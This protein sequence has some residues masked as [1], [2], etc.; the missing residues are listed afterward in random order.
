MIRFRLPS[1]ILEGDGFAVARTFARLVD[2]ARARD[3]SSLEVRLPSYIVNDADALDLQGYDRGLLRGRTESGEHFAARLQAWRYPRGHRVRGNAF[4]LLDQISE[5]FGGIACAAIDRRGNHSVRAADGSETCTHGNAWDWDGAPASPQWARFWT[6][7][8][9]GADI[10]IRPDWAGDL[11]VG[12]LGLLG[13]EVDDVAAIRGLTSGNGLLWKPAGTRPEWMIIVPEGE[14]QPAPNGLWGTW[15]KVVAGVASAARDPALRYVSLSPTRNNA[16][17]GD[18]T[19]FP[20]SVPLVSGALVSGNPARF[21]AL[22]RMPSGASYGG[23]PASFPATAQ[24]VDDGSPAYGVTHATAAEAVGYI[25]GSALPGAL[26]GWWS[27][28]WPEYLTLVSDRVSQADDLS[29]NA[30]HATQATAEYRPA[31]SADGFVRSS[32]E[33]LSAPAA[34]AALF[35]SDTTPDL[36]VVAELSTAAGAGSE[37]HALEVATPTGLYTD[38]PVSIRDGVTARSSRGLE[39]WRDCF[40]AG[41]GSWTGTGTQTN[42]LTLTDDATSLNGSKVARLTA[43]TSTEYWYITPGIPILAGAVYRVM[44]SV[45]WVGGA[46]PAVAAKTFD[47]GG[48]T[49]D[50][51]WCVG[52]HATLPEGTLSEVTVDWQLDKYR[53][54]TPGAGAVA[55]KL[56]FQTYVV[57]S[58]EGADDAS[59]DAISIV[60][61][62]RSAVAVTVAE[63]STR[64]TVVLLSGTVEGSPPVR[65]MWVDGV[66][67]AF[68]ACSAACTFS[69]ATAKILAGSTGA[70]RSLAI[71]TPKSGQTLAQ[72]AEEALAFA[73][74]FAAV[75]P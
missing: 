47:A 73:R 3:R 74:R 25:V 13:V 57:G 35:T 59:F 71:F 26:D 75:N 39:E 69:T 38:R 4:A 48:S 54:F 60:P 50:S 6:I 63:T 7:L 67:V 62:T 72:V 32:A 19:S 58:K 34:I 15:H 65:A 33:F 64:R 36:V 24:L 46:Y 21:P 49:V 52:F 42:P 16:Y 10:E 51:L 44:S 20:E 45:K 66:H 17:A 53:D 68:A 23:D 31:V 70:I 12:T 28:V 40:E 29:G 14:A 1:W 56:A 41:V 27:S 22:V 43:G 55:A 2:E 8:D 37:F 11:T 61:A 30:R 5:Y 9:G 18:P